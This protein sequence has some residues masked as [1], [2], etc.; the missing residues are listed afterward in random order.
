MPWK[1]LP[2]EFEQLRGQ[3]PC[4]TPVLIPLSPPNTTHSADTGEAGRKSVR[5]RQLTWHVANRRRRPS[6]IPGLSLGCAHWPPEAGH[7]QTASFH[8]TLC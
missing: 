3:E 2:W 4:V 8:L 7:C 6:L 5:V 1:S